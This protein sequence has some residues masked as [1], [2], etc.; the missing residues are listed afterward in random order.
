MT[1]TVDLHNPIKTFCKLFPV[2][3]K[4][5]FPEYVNIFIFQ[6]PKL[7]KIHLIENYAVLAQPMSLLGLTHFAY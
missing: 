6:V 2:F 1:K 7:A 4:T 5:I 3:V